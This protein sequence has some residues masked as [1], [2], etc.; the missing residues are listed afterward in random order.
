VDKEIIKN[1]TINLSG[2]EYFLIQYDSDSKDL[3]IH[4]N[5]GGG[6]ISYLEELKIFIIAVYSDFQ[7]FQN[8]DGISQKQD[9]GI[10]IKAVNNA[11]KYILIKNNFK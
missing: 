6:V 4:K 1:F 5:S 8:I 10:L 2:E 3:Y 9:L 7:K 11:K